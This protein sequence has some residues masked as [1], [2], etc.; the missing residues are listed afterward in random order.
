MTFLFCCFCV[1]PKKYFWHLRSSLLLSSSLHHLHLLYSLA[2]YSLPALSTSQPQPILFTSM[3]KEARKGFC[4]CSVRETIEDYKEGYL[5][6]WANYYLLATLLL[7]Y[8]LRVLVA[9]YQLPWQCTR[10]SKTSTK[11]QFL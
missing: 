9:P 10:S 5:M 8:T 6:V 11:F 7:G 4:C 2:Y 1:K 3:F